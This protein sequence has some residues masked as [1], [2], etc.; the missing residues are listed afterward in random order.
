V[1]FRYNGWHQELFKRRITPADAVWAAALM[2]QLNDRQWDDAFRAGGY[3]PTVAGRFKA[4]LSRRLAQARS[5][6]A[7][8]S[9]A[10][11]Q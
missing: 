4:A 5:V 9:T 3:D 2:S 7:P 10:A 8:V 11:P 6:K 1:V